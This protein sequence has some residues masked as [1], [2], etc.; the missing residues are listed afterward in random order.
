MNSHST[1]PGA[2]WEQVSSKAQ[3]TED[4]KTLLLICT[5]RL[6]VILGSTKL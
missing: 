6:T 5:R 2:L 1:T 3:Q 4:N